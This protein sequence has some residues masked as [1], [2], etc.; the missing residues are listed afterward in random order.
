MADWDRIWRSA[1]S[2]VRSLA[3]TAHACRRHHEIPGNELKPLV[4]ARHMCR[5]QGVNCSSRG[6]IV[7][8][9][10]TELAARRP[11]ADGG[12]CFEVKGL[13]VINGKTQHQGAGK[14]LARARGRIS[15]E[16]FGHI[17]TGVSD[18]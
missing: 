8:K 1:K 17:A 12:G 4:I 7:P 10:V 18:R 3:R 6:R 13:Q 5:S 16:P 2:P 9:P 15:A 14:R 11:C